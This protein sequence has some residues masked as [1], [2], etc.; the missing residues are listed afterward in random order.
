MDHETNPADSADGDASGQ[1]GSRAPSGESASDAESGLA[2]ASPDQPGSPGIA[3]VQAPLEQGCAG[4][5]SPADDLDRLLEHG[6][7]QFFIFAK[8]VLPGGFLI[9]FSK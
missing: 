8:H 4:F 9:N 2:S 1:G 6:I 3:Y 5:L 7:R